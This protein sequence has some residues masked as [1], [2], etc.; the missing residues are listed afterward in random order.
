ML[1][2][3]VRW[4][5]PNPCPDGNAGSQGL[6]A[7][8]VVRV[9]GLG[10]WARRCRGPLRTATRRCR[11]VGWPSRQGG[12]GPVTGAGAGALAV[13][14]AGWKGVLVV[15]S[16]GTEKVCVVGVSAGCAALPARRAAGGAGLTA[17]VDAT[18]FAAAP[19]APTAASGTGR[20]AAATGTISA[21]GTAGT[22]AGSA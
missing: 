22:T 21:T 4:A 16:I 14:G 5:G 17:A 18:G 7:G 9:L 13:G 15:I 10:R 2:L 20:A 11:G 1:L 8:L 12:V 3:L 6:I 19:G